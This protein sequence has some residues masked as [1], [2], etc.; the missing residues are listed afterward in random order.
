MPLRTCCP[1]VGISSGGCHF[2]WLETL[3]LLLLVT[4]TDKAFLFQNH[5][6]WQLQLQPAKSVL[7]SSWKAQVSICCFDRHQQSE[8]IRYYLA[9][10]VSH[11][12][13]S[14]SRPAFSYT[15]VGRVANSVYLSLNLVTFQRQLFFWSKAAS[16]N[17]RDFSWVY[18][19]H[20]R[21]TYPYVSNL[22]KRVSFL[23]GYFLRE[24]RVLPMRTR[25]A[26]S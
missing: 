14:S 21:P 9:H 15:Q 23:R 5:N 20:W 11:V 22:R 10:A 7:L 25:F 17:S 24:K 3:Y 8:Q 19:R 26:P 18:W 16:D 2:F 1:L 12:F 4:V 6:V 13:K